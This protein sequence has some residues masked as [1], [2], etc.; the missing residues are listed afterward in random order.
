MNPSL[1]KGVHLIIIL[2]GIFFSTKTMAQC[3]CAEGEPANKIEHI[4]VLDT[5]LTSSTVLSFPKFDPAIGTLTCVRL[6]DTVSV[7]S[8][9]GIRNF[10]P[11]DIEYE[12]ILTVTTNIS[13]PSLTRTNS[14]TTNYGPDLLYAY[15]NPGD[16]INYGPDTLYK[17]VISN[18]TNT[19]NMTPYLGET[20]NVNFT[21]AI[22]GGTVA[23]GGASFNS[24]IR[25]SSW[26]VFK[27]TYFW[28]ENSVLAK[29]FKSFSALKH[30]NVVDLEWSVADDKSSNTYEIQISYDGRKFQNIGERNSNAAEGI[31]AKYLY[32]YHID[33]S[34]YRKAYFRIKQLTAGVTAY[35]AVRVVDLEQGNALSAN[36]YP[37]PVLRNINLNFTE[38]VTGDFVV[39]LTNQVGQL[40]YS[41]KTKVNNS[42]MLQVAVS[43]PPPPGVYY[44]R[45]RE[46]AT[47]KAFTGKLLFKN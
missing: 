6:D 45:A 46:M 14:R 18:R 29:N 28:C 1:L 4:I 9:T 30:D 38:P 10:D 40:V 44:L 39:H 21:Y 43:Q 42:N 27:L 11:S 37:N 31:A 23:F 36:I 22:G 19:T 5:T 47:G 32:Q 33:K 26:G 2:S 15:G 17:N 7:V 13:G 25:T 16:S 24:Q 35:S 12:F 41:G 8:R 34:A 3:A 20:G